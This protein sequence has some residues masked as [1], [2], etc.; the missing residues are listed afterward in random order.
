MKKLLKKI[1][2][3]T[4]PFVLTGMN[5][6]TLLELLVASIIAGI[7]LSGLLAFV[8]NILQTDRREQA[9]LQTQEEIQATL[10]FI[11]DDLK[12]AVYIYD[13]DGVER[14]SRD[15]PPGI[16]DQ[17]PRIDK[18]QPVL[19][20]W[21][22][23]FYDREF[24]TRIP[25][26]G[27]CDN[28]SNTSNTCRP[29]KALPRGDE[30]GDSVF[31]YALVAYYLRSN[32]DSDVRQSNSMQILRVELRDGIRST[33]Q[34]SDPATCCQNPSPPPNT[35]P[36]CLVP[37]RVDTDGNTANNI[38]NGDTNFWVVPDA[39]F[40]RFEV[41]GVGT[42]RDR[43]NRWTNLERDRDKFDL[44]GVNEPQV[45]L[46]FVDD[47]FYTPTQDDVDPNNNPI[48]VPI[49][50]NNVDIS[51]LGGVGTNGF[52]NDNVDC[53]DPIRGVGRLGTGTITLPDGRVIY[54]G[55]IDGD[56]RLDM[57]TQRIPSN[58]STSTDL[59][60]A[61]NASSFFVC[62]NSIQNVARVYIRGNALVRLYPRSSVNGVRRIGPTDFTKANFLTTAS[63]R[64]FGRSAI[65]RQ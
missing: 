55:D 9:K 64:V 46:D 11:A 44:R 23:H 41:T 61:D 37:T 56:G 12:Q 21:K 13:A 52:L 4:S 42:L 10:D 34:N 36:G 22:R 32:R 65:N 62:V 40:R 50:P 58:F 38:N 27:S 7:M 24:V 14:T 15:N 39:N 49:R 45:V 16:R 51:V 35:I 53:A 59:T 3:A 6:F 20:F 17:L 28:P 33:C 63:V 18:A 8:V 5:G 1:L 43:M 30:N 31:V 25:N 19:V 2:G 54:N 48:F 29:I 26:R 47:T 60:K 57:A